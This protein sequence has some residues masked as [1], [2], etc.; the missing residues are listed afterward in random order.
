M[1]R[2]TFTFSWRCYMLLILQATRFILYFWNRFY[3]R[4]NICIHI[5][6]TFLLNLQ[7][8]VGQESL[9][10]V[11]HWGLLHSN[12]CTVNTVHVGVNGVFEQ[13]FNA[14]ENKT[15]LMYVLETLDNVW[16]SIYQSESETSYI[17]S[18]YFGL[19][20]TTFEIC[21]PTSYCRAVREQQ[22]FSFLAQRMT[23]ICNISF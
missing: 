9:H 10:D 5:I 13:D 7:W 16:V 3:N 21:L 12:Y 8:Q 1:T 17:L 11:S 15:A 2:S 14:H 22:T 6:L 23:F 20:C 4:V 19:H 18:V